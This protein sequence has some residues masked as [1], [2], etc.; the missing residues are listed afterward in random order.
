M[1]MIQ[2]TPQASSRIRELVAEK[3]TAIRTDGLRISVDKGG[4]SGMEYVLSVDARKDGDQIFHGQNADVLV[5]PASLVF[6][7]GSTIDYVDELSSTGFKI[8]NPKAKQTCGCG[9]SFET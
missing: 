3:K 7:D 4:C 8:L 2:I 9:T 6:I 1:N 5:D